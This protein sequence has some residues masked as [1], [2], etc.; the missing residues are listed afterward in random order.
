MDDYLSIGGQNVLMDTAMG[1][2]F[3]VVGVS[4][5]QQF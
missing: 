3:G 4:S 1:G 2:L 5:L